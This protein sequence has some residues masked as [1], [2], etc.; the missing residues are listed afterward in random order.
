MTDITVI[1]PIPEHPNYEWLET[2]GTI[3]SLNEC[4]VEWKVVCTEAETHRVREAL[5]DD[6]P[7]S[8]TVVDTTK[9]V[10]RARNHA[11]RE[12]KGKYVMQFDSDDT[13]LDGGLDLLFKACEETGLV[14]SGGR[15]QDFWEPGDEPKFTFPDEWY[16]DIGDVIPVGYTT[17]ARRFSLAYDP[18]H[19]PAGVSTVH[20]S[21]AIVRTDVA[22]EVGGWD[23]HLARVMDDYSF[24]AKVN[25]HHE[26]AWTNTV[27]FLYRLHGTSITAKKKTQEEWDEIN[28]YL[29]LLED[30]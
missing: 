16:D 21:S 17:E 25:K 6:M 22:L 2:V 5:P 7:I 15:A 12:A 9:N 28:N 19:F 11:L 29:V 20:P 23:E 30:A 26:G 24:I 14:W 4:D 13:P 1:T 10:A 27:T 3:T 18:E 8:F